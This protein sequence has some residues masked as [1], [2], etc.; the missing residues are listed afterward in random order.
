MR[1]AFGLAR[2]AEAFSG[3]RA[4]FF[5]SSVTGMNLA[6]PEAYRPIM[7]PPFLKTV[8][9]WFGW[10]PAER[11]PELTE[12]RG[13]IRDLKLAPAKPMR[14]LLRLLKTARASYGSVRGAKG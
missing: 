7:F 8:T 10:A 2:A 6:I 9:A 12:K 3:F 11:R 5:P 13:S 4:R 1:T 14:I